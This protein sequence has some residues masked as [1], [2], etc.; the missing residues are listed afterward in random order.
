VDHVARHVMGPF[1]DL[2]A[3]VNQEG[4]GGPSSEDH[5]LCRYVE[6]RFVWVDWISSKYSVI[7]W[8]T[9][10]SRLDGRTWEPR[11]WDLVLVCWMKGRRGI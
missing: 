4:V 1:E 9:G 11:G 2:G 8:A 5:N 6:V 7:N 3:Y 10:E